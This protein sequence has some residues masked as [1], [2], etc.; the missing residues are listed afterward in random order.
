MVKKNIL[1]VFILLA[2]I[3]HG[4]YLFKQNYFL[5]FSLTPSLPY[6]VFFVNKKDKE[7]IKNDLIVF[8][9][10]GQNI[11]A[12]K[13]G[14]KFVKI[15]SCFPNDILITNENLEYYCN[16]KIIGKAYLYDSQG[17]R[18]SHFRFN[19]PIP[20]DKYFVTG[21]HPKSWDSKYWGFVS[22]DTIIGKA[23]GLL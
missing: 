20:K 18:L 14:E 13:T 23:K 1:P 5:G 21:T 8:A 7:F 19:G 3:A 4:I 9:Y 15:A 11:Y 10:P 17:K 12:Y 22:K 6:N 16:G 2:I